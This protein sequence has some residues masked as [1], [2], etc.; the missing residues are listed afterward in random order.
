MY[1]TR[2]LLL[3]LVFNVSLILYLSSHFGQFMIGYSFLLCND[4]QKSDEF[5][6]NKVV[7]L[8]MVAAS[9]CGA[10]LQVCLKMR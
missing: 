5:H 4:H 6:A 9:C 3:L 2:C 8:N 1:D 10:I 7:L